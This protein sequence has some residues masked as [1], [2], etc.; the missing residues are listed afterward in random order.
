MGKLKVQL[1]FH[2][3][4]EELLQEEDRTGPG[5]QKGDTVVTRKLG[6]G[7]PCVGPKGMPGLCPPETPELEL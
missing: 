5:R 3:P 1:K 4:T 7:K 2:L 6:T